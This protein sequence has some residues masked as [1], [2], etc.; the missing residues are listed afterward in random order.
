[1]YGQLLPH[2]TFFQMQGGGE[3]PVDSAKA[4]NA[5]FFR[6]ALGKSFNQNAGSRAALVAN[7]GIYRRPGS[8]DRREN[9]L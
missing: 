1:M 8:R 5:V 7:D 9:E 6:A 4:P 3:V 2:R